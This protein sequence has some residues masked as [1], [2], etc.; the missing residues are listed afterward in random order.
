MTIVGIDLGTTNSLISVWTSQE[1]IIIPNAL[2]DN[3]TPSVVGVDDNGEILVGKA[4]RERLITHPDKTTALFK[5]YMGSDKKIKLGPHVFRPEELSAFVLR[6]LK[7]DAEA[8]LGEAVTEAVISVPAYFNDIQRKATRAAGQLA[9]LKVERLINEPT[10]AAI[11]YGLHQRKDDATILIFDLGGGT[12]DV[13]ILEFFDGVMEV[14]ATAGDSFVGGED[15]VQAIVKS[16]ARDYEIIL[17]ELDAASRSRL[18]RKAEQL[19]RRL[20]FEAGASFDI[21][22]NGRHISNRQFFPIFPKM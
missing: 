21:D 7:Q 17:E 2:N 5:R 3:M 13:S 18:V 10:A 12:F 20:T 14:H 9:G 11:A 4:A 16:F 22:L 15:F 19:K 8:I 6:S 1:A